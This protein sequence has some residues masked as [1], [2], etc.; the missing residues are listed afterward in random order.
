MGT[1]ECVEGFVLDEA[2][3]LCVPE[4]PSAQAQMS[5]P[6]APRKKDI[7]VKLRPKNKKVLAPL[8]GH[9]SHHEGMPVKKKKKKK[10]TATS[11]LAD[12]K[13]GGADVGTIN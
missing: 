10:V 11:L 8:D 4:S 1:L 5:T 2:L 12:I 3:G 9:G 6:F 7:P 13:E